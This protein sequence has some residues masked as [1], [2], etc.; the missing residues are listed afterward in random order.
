[1][2]CDCT[3]MY[4]DS[5]ACTRLVVNP[6]SSWCV[7]YAMR[8]FTLPCKAALTA[9]H[10]DYGC[11]RNTAAFGTAASKTQLCHMV[12]ATVACMAE[13]VLYIDTTN[14]FSARRLAQIVSQ[15]PVCMLKTSQC[16]ET[17]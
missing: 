5:D 7:F 2:Q 8:L 1:M 12:A 4:Y 6:L 14:S 3:A 16:A 9:M 10:R 11:V 17:L 15:L 13:Y